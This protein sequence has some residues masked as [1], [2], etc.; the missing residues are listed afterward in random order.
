MQAQGRI[1]QQALALTRF[2]NNFKD[3]VFDIFYYPLN[4]PSKDH[5]FLLFLLKLNKWNLQKL[6]FFVVESTSLLL[7]INGIIRK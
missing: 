3:R 2:S 6:N 1:C 5:Q 4:D 7:R